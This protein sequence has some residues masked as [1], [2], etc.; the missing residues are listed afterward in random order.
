MEDQKRS[1]EDMQK[2]WYVIL[3]LRKS[4]SYQAEEMRGVVGETDTVVRTEY[5]GL[6]ES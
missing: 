5:K 3:F 6:T 2:H 1:A 4:K